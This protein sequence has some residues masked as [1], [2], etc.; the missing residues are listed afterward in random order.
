MKRTVKSVCVGGFTLVE[1]LIVVALITILT[2]LIAPS[3]QGLL[4]VGGRQGG[5]N[6]LSAALEQ[7]RLSAMQS[8]VKAYLAFPSGVGT[9]LDASSFIVLRQATEEEKQSGAA[10]YK[11]VTRW[12]RLPI[13]IFLERGDNFDNGTETLSAGTG[14][15]KLAGQSPANLKAITFDRFGKLSGNDEIHIKLGEKASGDAPGFL[16]NTDNYV[17][18]IIHPLTGR[19]EVRERAGSG[20]P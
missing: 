3:I 4:G 2:G 10:D 19:V 1:L 12:L 18:F 16:R 13:G 17:E 14:I 8:G 9:D 15:P 6:A 7:A 20:A 11:A 5:V